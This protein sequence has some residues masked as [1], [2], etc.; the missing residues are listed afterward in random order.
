[1]RI[2]FLWARQMYTH[3]AKT[4]STCKLVTRICSPPYKN[5]GGGDAG[6]RWR[7]RNRHVQVQFVVH[8]KTKTSLFC[9]CGARDTAVSLCNPT[10]ARPCADSSPHLMAT[11]VTDRFII[12]DWFRLP[13]CPNCCWSAVTLHIRW[14][15]PWNWIEKSRHIDTT[16]LFYSPETTYNEP[17]SVHVKR[18]LENR[19]LVRLS[20]AVQKNN[21][22]SRQHRQRQTCT[23]TWHVCFAAI[24][25]KLTWIESWPPSFSFTVIVI[26]ASVHSAF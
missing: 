9:A 13:M 1:M 3:D 23:P 19:V 26:A 16:T 22:L 8:N 2:G 25:L 17:R 20:R 7:E 18:K 14:A 6:T 11:S 5:P 24:F 10:V 4:S 12:A 15:F 21:G